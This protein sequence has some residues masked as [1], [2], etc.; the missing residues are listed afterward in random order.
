MS[1]N[2]KRIGLVIGSGGVK[3]A[4]TLG[5]LSVLNEAGIEVDLTVGC[6]GGSLYT[7]AIALGY[8]VHTALASS[9]LV[10]LGNEEQCQRWLPDDVRV[11]LDCR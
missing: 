4:A 3:C 6:S 9:A 2:S 11:K 1:K 7:A 10:H 8:Y 5:L